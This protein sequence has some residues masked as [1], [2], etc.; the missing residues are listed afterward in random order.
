MPLGIQREVEEISKLTFPKMEISIW[1]FP[2]GNVQNTSACQE[3]RKEKY[4]LTNFFTLLQNIH[5]GL[6]SRLEI[7]FFFLVLYKKKREVKPMSNYDDNRMSDVDEPSDEALKNLD[8][9]DL[10][11]FFKQ[12]KELAATVKKQAKQLKKRRK[13]ADSEEESDKEESDKEDE[14]SEEEKDAPARVSEDGEESVQFEIFGRINYFDLKKLIQPLEDELQDLKMKKKGNSPEGLALVEKI[15]KQVVAYYNQFLFQVLDKNQLCEEK[16]D[17]DDSKKIIYRKE[18]KSLKDTYAEQAQYIKKW[19]FSPHRR[20]Y[21]DFVFDPREAEHRYHANGA[22]LYNMFSGFA[23]PKETVYDGDYLEA[24]A[25]LRN[26]ILH[27][28][29]NG[30]QEHADY[31]EKWMAYTVQY[32]W[33]KIGVAIVMRG[34]EGLG[35]GNLVGLLAK[36]LGD[37]YYWHATEAARFYARFVPE[38]TLTSKL[39]YAD[40]VLYAGNKAQAD[41]LKTKI[42]ESTKTAETKYQ[43]PI[44]VNCVTNYIIASNHDFVVSAGM[45]ERRFFIVNCSGRFA[46]S[47]ERQAAYH[48][49]YANTPIEAVAQWL[50]SVDLTDWNPRVMPLTEALREQKKNSLQPLKRWWLRCLEDGEIYTDSGEDLGWPEFVMY[51]RLYSSLKLYWK[52]NK[53]EHTGTI[54][55]DQVF[56]MQFAAMV[57]KLGKMQKKSVGNHKRKNAYPIENLEAC[58]KFFCGITND[59]Q[60]FDEPEEVANPLEFVMPTTTHSEAVEDIAKVSSKPILKNTAGVSRSLPADV[61]KAL[62]LEHEAAE[63]KLPYATFTQTQ[64]IHVHS[65]GDVVEMPMVYDPKCRFVKV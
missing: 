20:R 29:C 19:A 23:H 46:G 58:K 64:T 35:K 61:H 57:P 31:I 37:K 40:E 26:H 13:V 11:A 51:D 62:T 27:I 45:C 6:S 3:F 4:F 60:W 21:D 47:G 1:T 53:I 55:S 43:N 8:L 44:E 56:P 59:P 38:K 54:P 2:S 65:S 63:R 7:I 9:E 42:T 15:D 34:A 33:K 24:V 10:R 49:T 22:S 36:V 25:N 52:E 28:I 18:L 48:G 50:Y 39:I 17:F 12:Q 16:L 30:V 32:P 41:I 5:V 14:D